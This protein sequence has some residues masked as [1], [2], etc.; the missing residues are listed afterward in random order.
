MSKKMKY[1]ITK[2]GCPILFGQ[3]QQHSEFKHFNPTSAGFCN[4]SFDDHY[5]VQC[6]GESTS[7][8]LAS[9][10]NDSIKIEVM[11]NEY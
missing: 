7:L 8:N 3:A 9:S 2:T 6:Y 5:K 10:Q 1:I 4:I 11:L